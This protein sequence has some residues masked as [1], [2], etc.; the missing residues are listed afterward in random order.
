M[1]MKRYEE[2]QSLVTS[3]ESDFRKFYA[4][5]NKEAGIRLRKKMQELRRFAVLVRNEVQAHQQNDQQ[6]GSKQARQE[7]QD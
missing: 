3:C 6:H 2:L 5:G 7:H 1:N 4:K